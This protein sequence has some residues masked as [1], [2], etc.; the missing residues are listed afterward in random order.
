MKRRQY[1]PLILIVSACA[2][3]PRGAPDRSAATTLPECA[4]V[5]EGK[6]AILIEERETIPEVQAI[7]TR[8]GLNLSKDLAV[9][10]DAR[11]SGLFM[12]NRQVVGRALEEN[13]PAILRDAGRA[14]S[15]NILAHVDVNG[16]VTSTRVLQSAGGLEFAAASQRVVQQM[17][18]YPAHYEG[19]R[20]PA[21]V[22]LPVTFSVS[23]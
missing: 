3:V 20:L 10:V 14:G 7:L 16:T 23:P 22:R 6:V 12:R 1:L 8:A 4:G 21:I 13:Y 15:A 18:F 11:T 9:Y 17:R 2:S 5:S 19:C